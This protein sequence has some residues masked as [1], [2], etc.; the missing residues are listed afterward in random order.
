MNDILKNL[1][2]LYVEDEEDIRRNAVEYLRRICKKVYEAKDG[3]EALNIWREYHPDIII[4]DINMP[5]LNGIDMA[6]YIRSSDLKTQI[7][8]ATAHTETD[9][10]MRAVELQLVKYLVKPITKD[11]LLEALS[12]SIKRIEDKSKFTLKLSN[13]CN[14]NAFTQSV[15]CN[16][17]EVKL[18]TN[19]HL[20]MALLVQYS[21]R[22]VKYEEIESAIWP[23]DGMSSDAIRSLVRGL[24]KKV[25][26]GCILNISGS[27]YKLRLL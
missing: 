27:G 6:Q 4:T 26:K 9:Y 10:L 19:E 1:T 25:P 22:V 18:T 8:I 3:K 24:R 13:E 20:F 2:L 21:S 5:R 7:I 11:K 12:Q 23:I 14:Y 17:I 16:K 15:I